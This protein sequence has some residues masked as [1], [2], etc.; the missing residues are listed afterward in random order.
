MKL[1][2]EKI[3]NGRIGFDNEPSFHAE[4]KRCGW[5]KKAYLIERDK[6]LG[7]SMNKNERPIVTIAE[8]KMAQNKMETELAVAINRF[9]RLAEGCLVRDVDVRRLN[10]ISAG[11][12]MVSIKIEI[13]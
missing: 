4:L 9:E 7:Y 12:V 3:N 11:E 8:I 13:D 5:P 1:K 6:R 10:I 2:F